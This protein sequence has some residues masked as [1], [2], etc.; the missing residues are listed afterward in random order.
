MRGANVQKVTIVVEPETA[1]WLHHERIE[2][3]ITLG[4]VIDSILADKSGLMARLKTEHQSEVKHGGAGKK[5]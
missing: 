5:R 2:R 1:R 4:E 3:G